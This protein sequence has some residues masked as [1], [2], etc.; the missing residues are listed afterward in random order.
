MRDNIGTEGKTAAVS[1]NLQS[2]TQS[3][4]GFSVISDDNPLISP[5]ILLNENFKQEQYVVKF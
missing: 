2:M 5:T 3:L 4:Q 1:Y